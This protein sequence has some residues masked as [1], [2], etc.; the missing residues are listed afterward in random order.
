LAD[1]QPPAATST[2]LPPR[3]AHGKR[4]ARG[5]AYGARRRNRLLPSPAVLGATALVV[6]GAGAVIVS[7]NTSPPA[8]SFPY[9]T[10]AAD[11]EGAADA[12]G[13]HGNVIAI[14][15]DVDRATL[16]RQAEQQAEQRTKALAE[17]ARITQERADKLQEEQELEQE[18]NQWVLPVAGYSLTATFGESSYLW[19][20]VHTGLDF[21][22][23]SGTPIVSVA[24]GVVT[25]ATYDGAYGYK[26]VVTLDDGTEIWYCHQTSLAV[27]VG[28]EVNPGELIGYVGSTGNVTG[29][30]LHLEVR[31]GGGDPVDPYAAL[32][33]HDVQP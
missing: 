5:P 1:G 4:A 3:V 16:Q 17:L 22:A 32:V 14:S 13:R 12:Y 21:A 26:T 33:A 23:P 20:T 8:P 6:A 9:A 24:H 31:P 7:S 29:P 27:S 30:H 28:E 19:S 11:L 10:L 18:L 2:A 25:E 15:R